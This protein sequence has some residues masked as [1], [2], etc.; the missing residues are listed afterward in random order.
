MATTYPNTQQERGE[1]GQVS[2]GNMAKTYRSPTVRSDTFLSGTA[3]EFMTMAS[4]K[5]STP[6]APPP[7]TAGVHQILNF[8]PR[9][10]QFFCHFC[11]ACE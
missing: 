3:N 2:V 5:M 10:V 4:K 1:K 8:R 7:Y 11:F 9:L 6:Q